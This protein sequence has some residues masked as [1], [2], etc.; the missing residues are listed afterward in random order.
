ML[1]KR[2]DETLSNE[3]RRN[4]AHVAKILQFASSKIGNTQWPIYLS[5]C[6][7]Q[8]LK[9]KFWYPFL[10]LSSKLALSHKSGQRHILAHVAKILQVAP[11][12]DR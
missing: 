11:K 10:L 7:D 3:Q 12:K 6:M 2:K 5:L 8:P 4:L 1:E 9:V